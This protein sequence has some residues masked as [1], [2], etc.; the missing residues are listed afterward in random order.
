MAN[1]FIIG[2]T[3][4]IAGAITKQ[5]LNHGH[6][7]GLCGRDALK[8]ETIAHEVNAPFFI[9]DAANFAA[10]DQ[11]FEQYIN[12]VGQIDGVVNCAGSLLLKTAEATDET[13]YLSVIESNLTTAF[14]TVHA[15]QKHMGKQGGSVL[16]ISSAAALTG[17]PNHEAIAA[18]KAGIIGLTAAAAASSASKNL[19]FNALA[20]GL[21]NT[22]LTH[23]MLSTPQA[24]L[25]SEALHPLGRIGTVEDI[26]RAA[27]FF[28]NPENS[29]I[30]GQ[31]LA[32]DGGLSAIKPKPKR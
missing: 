1:F 4:T 32:V 12:T 6:Q 14:A 23:K 8:T 19:R 15:A 27:Y 2:A 30:T 26:A 17:L 25:Y 5:L 24:L 7:L 10:L 11:A 3:S 16:L 31:V 28:L 13:E 20:P 29:W 9:A 21:V 18:A 22:H